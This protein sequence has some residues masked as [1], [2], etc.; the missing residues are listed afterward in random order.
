[1]ATIGQHISNLR[2]LIK[3]YGRTDESYSDQFLY[4][5]LKGERNELISDTL[6]KFNHVSEWNWETYCMKLIKTKPHNCDCV[7]SHLNCTVLRSKYKIPQP[8]KGRNKSYIEFKTL[9]GQEIALYDESEWL[10]I[11]EDDIRSGVIS[12]SII[13]GYLFIWNNLTLR[14]FNVGGIWQ[15]QMEW[16][17]IPKCDVDGEETSDLCFNP[18]TSE[19]PLDLEKQ[20]YIYSK[21]LTLLKIPIQLPQDITNDSNESIKV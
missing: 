14:V 8:V 6:R 18:L 20:N 21:V 7:P 11:K 1:M 2:G 12:A 17:S 16:Q 9:G 4:Q 13:N 5:L 19:F 15:D 3:Q 10:R